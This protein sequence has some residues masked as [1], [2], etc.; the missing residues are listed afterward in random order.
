MIY[1]FIRPHARPGQLLIRSVASL[2]LL[3]T[4]L[5][6]SGEAQAS[7][8]PP[9]SVTR[10]C[11]ITSTTTPADL[12]VSQYF[13]DASGEDQF[14]VDNI[15]DQASSLFSI[16]VLALETVNTPAFS[17]PL[18]VPVQTSPDSSTPIFS[19]PAGGSTV[20]AIPNL[21]CGEQVM[22][23]VNSGQ[24]DKTRGG[25]MFD[26]ACQHNDYFA[27]PFAPQG[28]SLPTPQPP[29]NI[30]TVSGVAAAEAPLSGAGL[31]FNEWQQDSVA[32]L[33]QINAASFAPIT[34]AAAILQVPISFTERS[35]Q[36]MQDATAYGCFNG[37]FPDPYA[38]PVGDHA[39][40]RATA[41]VCLTPTDGH[42]YHL[43]DAGPC[44]DGD[45]N[46]G[47]WYM[48][49]GERADAYSAPLNLN[50]PVQRHGTARPPHLQVPPDRTIGG[51]LQVPVLLPS[52]TNV[53][54]MQV[55]VELHDTA[56]GDALVNVLA[57]G[58]NNWQ[59]AKAAAPPSPVMTI[60]VLPIELIQ[61]KVLPFTIVYAPVGDK[62]T[63]KFS[64]SDTFA[65][66]MTVGNGTELTNTTK[67]TTTNMVSVEA[68]LG[69]AVGF[70]FKDTWNWEHSTTS[71]TGVSRA[72]QSM[73][74]QQSTWVHTWI[75]NGRADTVPGKGSYY[76][77]PWWSDVFV[78]LLDPQMGVY[79]FNGT[80]QVQLLGARANG[81]DQFF[82]AAATDL[83]ACGFPRLY[84]TQNPD[85]AKQDPFVN[86][87]PLPVD[88]AGNQETLTPA[89]CRNLLKLDPFFTGGG[90][91]TQPSLSRVEGAGGDN[92]GITRSGTHLTSPDLA[93]DVQI[94]S[95]TTST[96]GTTLDNTVTDTIGNT[97]AVGGEG[98][99]NVGP[100]N[101]KLGV[102][103]SHGESTVGTQEMKI[104]Y[105][106]ST[107][108]TNTHDTHIEGQLD[109]N[110]PTS[111]TGVSYAPY[112]DYF[113]DK[114]FGSIMF[115]DPDAPLALSLALGSCPIACTLATP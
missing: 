96:M 71:G 17:G 23:A 36:A 16:S 76:L 46:P 72:Q 84:T 48:L 88:S 87:L 79:D 8:A 33:Q 31:G 105:G 92:Y 20:Y 3:A 26:A 55:S 101:A 44:T 67:Q 80:P 24:A 21:T 70:D 45:G 75:N 10:A 40:Y 52:A 83:L 64:V 114:V 6:G 113:V 98:N 4:A 34:T 47:S 11:L 1:V 7:L 89:E 53:V 82:E 115:R 42:N 57:P 112:V 95:G 13:T 109:D 49:G 22:V 99:F 69:A 59:P 30:V 29:A 100:F 81:N 78:L 102:A 60:R 86:G 68:G 106:S 103:Y 111:K 18:W 61:S 93:H 54:R 107:A 74:G 104:T 9:C 27:Y 63:A 110:N 77:Q 43:D 51:M 66:N 25:F 50:W 65:V 19:L 91:G 28:Q 90:Q 108:V 38:C 35:S 14:V 56:L 2:S 58:E 62:S 94:T 15:G 12:I 41:E 39:V 97:L 37:F 85:L 5:L 73:T 32:P